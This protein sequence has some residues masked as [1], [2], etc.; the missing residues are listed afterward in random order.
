MSKYRHIEVNKEEFPPKKRHKKIQEK[1]PSNYM[2]TINL[3]EKLG[4]KMI[5]NENLLKSVN[6]RKSTNVDMKKN[7]PN[8]NEEEKYSKTL[9]S[10]SLQKR[11][12]CI[13]KKEYISS[14]NEKRII[15]KDFVKKFVSD[16]NKIARIRK[17]IKDNN[18]NKE[19]DSYIVKK[20]INMN[21]KE[22]KLNISTKKRKS[23]NNSYFNDNSKKQVNI[24]KMSSK[25]IRE[26]TKFN[27]KKEKVEKFNHVDKDNYINNN[28]NSAHKR[29][30][31]AKNFKSDKKLTMLN[32]KIKIAENKVSKNIENIS[33]KKPIQK[34]TTKFKSSS[35]QKEFKDKTPHHSPKASVKNIHD[36]NNKSKIISNNLKESIEKCKTPI[37]I[38]HNK[39]ICLET[40]YSKIVKTE[41]NENKQK[42]NISTINKRTSESAEPKR[43]KRRAT[44]IMTGKDANLILDKNTENLIS[45]KNIRQL[46][47]TNNYGR[48]RSLDNP[49]AREKFENLLN[50]ITLKQNGGNTLYLTNYEKGKVYNCKIELQIKNKNYVRNIKICSCTKP[51]CSGPGIVKTNQDAFFIKE[52]FLDN[53]NNF[54]FGIC[55][56]HGEKGQIISQYVSE[57]LPEYINNIK[58]DNITNEFKK[59]NNEIYENKNIESDMSG[60]TVS[61]LI[62]TSS[63]IISINLGDSRSCLFKYEND[64]YTFKNLTRDHKPSQNEESQRIINNNG[65]IK[66]FYDEQHK[67]YI[68]PERVWLKNKEEPGLAMTRSIGDKIAHCIGVIEEPEFKIYEYDGNEKFIIIASDGIW[69]YLN[70]DDC[71]K[72]VKNYYEDNYDVEKASFSLVKEAFDKWKRKEVTIDDIT[73][74][75]IFFCD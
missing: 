9:K 30:K 10:S 58:H 33:T 23:N 32:Y 29:N 1:L 39:R 34:N 19:N 28:N 47:N 24:K 2:Q 8:F 50:A 17:Y 74:I 16:N 54:F 65:R 21:K 73:A 45:M 46:I 26:N 67:K 4:I 66:R 12:Q 18:E 72:I 48:R 35:V 71:I 64:A 22:N 3:M 75:V 49:L 60:T 40:Y 27:D 61:S 57:K 53:E 63:K 44:E 15:K 43:S 56:G 52:K 6:L 38:N 69:E 59:I 37:K 41:I 36:K 68:G 31:E 42:L 70:G 25:K 5:N 14:S 11:K 20:T 55:D 13:N 62:L 7:I 51:G